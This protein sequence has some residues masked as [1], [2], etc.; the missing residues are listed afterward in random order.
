[1]EATKRPL[2]ELFDVVAGYGPV[3]VLNGLAFS[4][5]PNERLAV[6]GNGVGKTTFRAVIGL[7]QLQRGRIISI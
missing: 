7:A 4:V 6:I 3:T 5:A 1:M 2:L